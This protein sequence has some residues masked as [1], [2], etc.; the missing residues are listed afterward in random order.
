MSSNYLIVSFK[1]FSIDHYLNFF[2][3]NNQL[4][5]VTIVFQ[6]AVLKFVPLYDEQKIGTTKRLQGQHVLELHVLLLW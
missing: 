1:S 4:E 5:V 2:R 6:M 3:K